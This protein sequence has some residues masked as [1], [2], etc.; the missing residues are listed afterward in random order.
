MARTAHSR[1]NTGAAEIFRECGRLLEQQGGNPF[2]VKAYLRAAGVLESLPVDATD[3][4]RQEGGDGLM[5]LPGIGTGLAA[6]IDEIARTGRLS[7]LDRLRGDADPEALLQTVPGIGPALARLLHEAL[8]VD[9]LEGLEVAAYDGRLDSVPGIGRRRLFAIRSA[10]AAILG[11]VRGS[12]RHAAKLPG[13]ELLLEVDREYRELAKS[14]KL[15]KIAPRRFNPE[16]RAW[17]P[18]LH[19]ERDGWHFTV[20]FSNT[21]QANKLRRTDDWVVAYFYNDDHEEGQHTIVTETHGRLKGK[22]VVRG[23]EAECSRLQQKD[24]AALPGGREPPR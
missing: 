23:R 2:Q 20:L 1:F 24:T 12:R 22:R 13:V 15:P 14:G 7:R 8:D 21:A 5:R 16:K 19:T 10:L 11:P 6:A 18:V 17:L 9:S 4:L 3:I